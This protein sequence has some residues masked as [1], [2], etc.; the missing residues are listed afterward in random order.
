MKPRNIVRTLFAFCLLLAI[1]LSPDLALSQEQQAPTAPAG[2]YNRY[3]DLAIGIPGR[4]VNTYNNAGMVAIAYGR[5]NQFNQNTGQFFDQST[6]NIGEDPGV[7]DYFGQALTSG[8]F[9]GDGNV[10]L[11][12][13]TPGETIGTH[14]NAGYVTIVYADTRE[15]RSQRH[16][17]QPGRDK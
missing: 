11:A 8:D 10:D 12:I 15:C 9:N 6:P 1:C 5:Y 3:A 16:W 2:Q 13:G 17:R 7:L 4:E 14:T